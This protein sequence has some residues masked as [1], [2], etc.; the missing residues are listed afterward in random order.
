MEARGAS[1]SE[2]KLTSDD[3]KARLKRFVGYMFTRH[4][5]GEQ[6]SIGMDRATYGLNSNCNVH[7][8]PAQGVVY[9]LRPRRRRR[10]LCQMPPVPEELAEWSRDTMLATLAGIAVVGGRQYMQERRAGQRP[11]RLPPASSLARCARRRS[12]TPPAT[13][14]LLLAG[15]DHPPADA[16]SKAHAA[17]AVAE[18]KTQRLARIANAATRWAFVSAWPVRADAFPALLLYPHANTLQIMAPAQGRA[19]HRRRGGGVLR[20]AAP[21]RGVP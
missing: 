20:D 21:E 5:P 19:A 9:V 16:P 3:R 14:A 7:A 11:R 18:E 10:R 4:D 6:V 8:R 2:P 13:P 15:P 17:R 1:V 12:L